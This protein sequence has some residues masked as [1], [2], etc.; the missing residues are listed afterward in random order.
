MNDEPKHKLYG[1]PMGE[2]IALTPGGLNDEV[3]VGISGIIGNG[4]YGFGLEGEQLIDF[5]R[6]SLY[7]LL[8]RGAK[9]RHWLMTGTPQLQ[10]GSDSPSEIVEGVIADWLKRGGGDLEWVD[11]R[12][13]LPK[14]DHLLNKK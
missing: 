8:E 9:P 2:W 4:R 1:T 6:R 14:Y 11:F 5:V 7:T 12:F 3:G 10:Y 13:S